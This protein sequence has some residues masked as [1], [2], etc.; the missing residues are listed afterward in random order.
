[1]SDQ[2]TQLF[3]TGPGPDGSTADRGTGGTQPLDRPKLRELTWHGGA[4]LGLLLLR[5][6]VGG[7]FF[8]HGM[9]KVF[10]L[11]GGPGIGGFTAF[12]QG[13]GFRNANVLA[14]A[15]AV[16]ELV[17]GAGVVLGL[18][19]PLAASGLLALMVNAV[20][21]KAGNGFFIAGPPGAGAVELDVVLGAAAAAIALTGAGRIA[22]DRGRTWNRRPAPWGF[23]CVIIGV[24]AALLVFFLLRA[25]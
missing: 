13:F 2:P 24:A 11:W 25:R 3:S 7:V 1:M 5:F 14:W 16:T 23:L 4:D 12:L 9:Q 21:L 10:G 15:T 17:G 22:L 8:A 19:T 20:L 18:F 6:A